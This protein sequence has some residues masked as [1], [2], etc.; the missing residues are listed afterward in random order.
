M[1]RSERRQAEHHIA[2]SPD[3]GERKSDLGWQA[4]Q[5]TRKNISAFLNA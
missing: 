5:R 2:Q 3:Q 1:P 4:K